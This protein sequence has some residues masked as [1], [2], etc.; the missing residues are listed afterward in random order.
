MPPINALIPASYS[1][2]NSS[3]SALKN[4][5]HFVTFSKSLSKNSLRIMYK[6][7]TYPPL[8][9]SSSC[10]SLHTLCMMEHFSPNPA[11]TRFILRDRRQTGTCIYKIGQKKR[12][13]IGWIFRQFSPSNHKMLWFR[14]SISSFFHKLHHY[15]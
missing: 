9:Y 1:Y 3:S 12:A 4:Q 5:T 15:Y 8:R 14:V 13:K 11:Q 10:W 2:K 6:C 7:R